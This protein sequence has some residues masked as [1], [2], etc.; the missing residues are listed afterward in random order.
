MN[1][2]HRLVPRLFQARTSSLPGSLDWVM[3]HE[4]ECSSWLTALLDISRY[5]ISRQGLLY[6]YIISY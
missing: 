3:C 6:T 5:L 4:L 1:Y 2:N